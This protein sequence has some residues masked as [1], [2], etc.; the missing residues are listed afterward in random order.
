MKATVLDSVRTSL[1]AL[2]E[3]YLTANPG[4]KIQR[5]PAMKV[6]KGF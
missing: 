3:E 1:E 6:K 5:I 4:A 2:E